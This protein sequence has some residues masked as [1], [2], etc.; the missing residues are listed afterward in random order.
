MDFGDFTYYEDGFSIK[1]QKVDR[2]ALWSEIEKIEAYKEDLMTY[3]ML[4]LNIDLK[5]S[6]ILI[7]EETEGYEYFIKELEKQFPSI[8]KGWDWKIIQS[9]FV[10]NH[11]VIFSKE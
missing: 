5:E 10:R 8:E 2:K 11:T 7:T 9:P 4:C 1:L 6:I 3:D